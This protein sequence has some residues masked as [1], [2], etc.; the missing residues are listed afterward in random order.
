MSEL[1][2][3][4]L[5]ELADA[6]ESGAASCR[7][8]VEAFLDRIEAFD[9]RIGAFV[10]R[11]RDA[12]LREADAADRAR[13]SGESRGPLHGLPVAIKDN[14]VSP[15][16]E[17]TCASRI[18]RGFR[19]PYEARE[20]SMPSVGT[21][22]APEVRVRYARKIHCTADLLMALR[23]PIRLASEFSRSLRPL[24]ELP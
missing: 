10:S 4:T 5:L 17:T 18:L 15:D 2:S 22:G 14:L 6:V 16:F 7:E 3:R 8:I 9:S 20:S 21:I 1:V 19:A 11:R 12:A 23:M 13:A 24:P